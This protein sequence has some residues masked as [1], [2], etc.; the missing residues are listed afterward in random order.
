M[1]FGFR[2]LEDYEQWIIDVGGPFAVLV[3]GLPEEERELIIAGNAG[4]YLKTG[5]YINANGAGNNKLL[6][7][8]ITAAGVPK[9]DFGQG[10]GGLIDAMVM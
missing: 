7:T 6:N 3:R 8:L 4:G 2:S 9:Q 1:H 5:Q 10:A